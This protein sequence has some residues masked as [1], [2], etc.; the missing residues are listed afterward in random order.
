MLKTIFLIILLNL[1]LIKT[2]PIV[3]CLCRVGDLEELEKLNKDY[4]RVRVEHSNGLNKYLDD[5][6]AFNSYVGCDSMAVY[7]LFADK[8]KKRCRS[9]KTTGWT[10]IELCKSVRCDRE[11]LNGQP[12]IQISYSKK[13]SNDQKLFLPGEAIA[14]FK[15]STDKLCKTCGF[16]GEWS[17]FAEIDL[18]RE[19][20]SL[21]TSKIGCKYESLKQLEYKSLSYVRIRMESSDGMKK[22]SEK[23][24][25][26]NELPA[27]S[28]VVYQR[29]LMNLPGQ[30][31]RMFSSFK[32]FKLT[33]PFTKKFCRYCDDGS[34][35]EI[36]SCVSLNCDKDLLTGNPDLILKSTNKA[37]SDEQSLF[38]PFSVVVM[39]KIIF[40]I[41]RFF[42]LLIS[43]PEK[44]LN[45]PIEIVLF[46]LLSEV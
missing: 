44:M 24:L 16:D 27:G 25:I 23:N 6:L 1:N 38:K 40:K 5:Q 12:T 10:E 29:Y 34:W 9:C 8:S 35:S 20:I 19:I 43:D 39:S 41:F 26:K 2:E 37:P 33:T 13:A 42:K 15:Y 11:V 28:V 45:S 7:E 17:K 18:C 22:F 46:Y 14:V 36:E 4:R 32:K 30:M 3:N 31:Y 21:K